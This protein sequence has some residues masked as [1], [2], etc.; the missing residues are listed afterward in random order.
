MSDYRIVEYL[1][2][3]DRSKVGVVLRGT[4]LTTKQVYNKLKS[5]F[6][7]TFNNQKILIPF[8]V[9]KK[10]GSNANNFIAL[11]V[12]ESDAVLSARSDLK[13]LI[14]DNSNALGSLSI[15]AQ[16]T[17]R[18]N[19]D[20]DSLFNYEQEFH[21]MIN[22][23]VESCIDIHSF[24]LEKV[25]SHPDEV[26]LAAEICV[27]S[28]THINTFDNVIGLMEIMKGIY[29]N[30]IYIGAVLS[31]DKLPLLELDFSPFS[32]KRVINTI[33]CPAVLVNKQIVE[34]SKVHNFFHN[35]I[36]LYLEANSK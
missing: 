35:I 20:I 14:A 21:D 19:Y 1:S 7:G 28:Q 5:V 3:D 11:S 33:D 31:H 25:S 32:T 36:S 12:V 2:I 22:F 15:G 27:L 10:S 29:S 9:I 17:L 26:V 30:P 18:I 6:F 16:L 24:K 23:A 8:S 34:I 13:K 4:D